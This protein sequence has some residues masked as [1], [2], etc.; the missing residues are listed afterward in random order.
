MGKE[1]TV[2]CCLRISQGGPSELLESSKYNK[3]EVDRDSSHVA[4]PMSK[5]ARMCTQ[6][7]IHG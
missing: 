3:R 5:S 6:L 2:G 1:N 7:K 4:L